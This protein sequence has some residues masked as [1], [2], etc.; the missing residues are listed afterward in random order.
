MRFIHLADV[1]LGL[2]YLTGD[3]P[4]V[5]SGKKRSGKLSAGLLRVSVKIRWICYL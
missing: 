3:A 4:G 1:H 5:K 2:E